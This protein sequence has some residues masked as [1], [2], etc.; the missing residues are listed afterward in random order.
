M[1]AGDIFPLL[2]SVRAQEVRDPTGLSI[3]SIA[4]HDLTRGDEQVERVSTGVK[5]HRI[6][7][8]NCTLGP[9]IR[10]RML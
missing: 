4:H 3:S 7:G 10:R 8:E 5:L 6:T 9:P 1:F 2:A